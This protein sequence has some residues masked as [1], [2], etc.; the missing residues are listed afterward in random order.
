MIKDY[1]NSNPKVIELEE[2]LEDLKNR[3]ISKR[4]L[5]SSRNRLTAQLSRDRQKLELT[6]LK[7]QCVNYHRLLRRLN[8]K[9]AD[10][11]NFCLKCRT[12]LQ[13]FLTQHQSLVNQTRAFS[14]NSV[15]A[16]FDSQLEEPLKRPKTD[17]S[18]ATSPSKKKGA[19]KSN[20]KKTDN[21][22]FKL[23]LGKRTRNLLT[24]GAM[25]ASVGA[26]ALTSQSQNQLFEAQQALVEVTQDERLQSFSLDTNF[27]RSPVPALDL[28]VP[29]IGLSSLVPYHLT[30]EAS[31][32]KSF[33]IEDA[34]LA[35]D[36]RDSYLQ[37]VSAPL[38]SH[39][40]QV[41]QTNSDFETVTC[42]MWRS[43]DYSHLSPA[44]NDTELDLYYADSTGQLKYDQKVSAF[45][46]NS[47]WLAWKARLN[48]CT[49]RKLL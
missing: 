34:Y 24:A 45:V 16:K 26:L 37:R 48:R 47:R 28:E 32:S 36:M 20:K 46:L 23:V 31:S 22:D 4:D 9:V 18:C 17:E 35:Y 43:N 21:E 10:K 6:F 2:A 30:A 29:S 44:V 14:E 13:G 39:A 1:Q 7:V 19:K 5:Q 42:N 38:A 12:T 41:T 49:A 8:K 40:E 15:F 11:D 25:L 27:L 3:S 33:Q